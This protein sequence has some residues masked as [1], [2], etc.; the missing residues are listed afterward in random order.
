M[1]KAID[2]PRL[3][4]RLSGE[5][6]TILNRAHVS[7]LLVRT[8]GVVFSDSTLDDRFGLI[9]GRKQVE[10]NTLL[11]QRSH[12]PL[13]HSVLLGTVGGDVYRA[14]TTRTQHFEIT[15]RREDAP[16]VTS[17]G[18][19]LGGGFIVPN[20]RMSASF[21]SAFRHLGV[22]SPADAI[23]HNL[24][25]PTVDHRNPIKPPGIRAEKVGHIRCPKKMPITPRIVPKM[26]VL[27]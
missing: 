16:V 27:I 19:P 3:S 21:K 2:A 11:F 7:Q 26:L 20:R 23:S 1:E 5:F 15:F 17:E 24:P 18:K 8:L 4:R 14:Q 6:M 25:I 9:K 10:P 13:D 22:L 12:E